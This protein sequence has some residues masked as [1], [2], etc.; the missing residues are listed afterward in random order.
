MSTN[1]D[2]PTV[3]WYA[4]DIIHIDNVQKVNGEYYANVL[5]RFDEDL[6]KEHQEGNALLRKIY[7]SADL[8]SYYAKI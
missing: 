6:K 7:K 4:H 2:M 3:I 5:N 1:K 8:R